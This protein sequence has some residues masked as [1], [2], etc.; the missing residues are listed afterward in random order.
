MSAQ[1][2]KTPGPGDHQLSRRE[3]QIMDI[4]YQLGEATVAQVR[5]AMEDSPSRNSLRTL[6]GILERKG[7]LQHKEKGRSFVYQPMQ[8]RSIAGSSAV[9]R[10]LST[11]FGGSLEEAIAVYIAQPNIELTD[12]ELRRIETLIRNA[13][14]KGGLR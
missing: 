12:E 1:R 8:P 2:R 14:K 5:A 10:V 7:H 3:R 6:L 9:R 13:R 4:V 11:F